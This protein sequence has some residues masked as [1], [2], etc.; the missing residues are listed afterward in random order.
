MIAGM[1]QKLQEWK[2]TKFV[3]LQVHTHTDGHKHHKQQQRAQVLVLEVD[4]K[5]LSKSKLHN[6]AAE[7]P[8]EHTKYKL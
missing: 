2:V 8:S 4:G 3:S 6:L 1:V 5:T 7:L